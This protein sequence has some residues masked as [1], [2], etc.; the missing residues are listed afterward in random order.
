MDTLSNKLDT[1][2]NNMANSNTVGYKRDFGIETNK[3]EFP[4][5]LASARGMGTR[6]EPTTFQGRGVTFTETDG[7]YALINDAGVFALDYFGKTYLT[8]SAI[9]KT[10][11]EGYLATK[12]GHRLIGK[13]GYI[14]TNG[15]KVEF[16]K[17][18]NIKIGGETVDQLYRVNPRNSI[19]IINSEPQMVNMYTKHEQGALMK[20][21]DEMDAAIEG[22]GFFTI[23]LKGEMVYSRAGNFSRSFEGYLITPDGFRVQGEKGDIP[24]S[25]AP[26]NIAED[27]VITQNGET[28]DKLKITDFQ[29]YRYLEKITGNTFKK[30]MQFADE[31]FEKPFTGV[32]KQG[33]LE[34]SNVNTVTEMVDV[35]TI[36]RNYESSQKVIQAYDMIMGKAV[37]DIGRLA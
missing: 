8:K 5:Y 33:Y 6:M 20:S 28:I 9:L 11:S 2:T 30:K 24:I 1:V 25:D 29:D 12:E 35:I 10:D 18:G 15:Q 36:N 34:S 21:E 4:N 19:G 22:T 14:Q 17:A 7:E 32:I 3:P 23:D 26:F 16:D 27:G 31:I 13:K 37:N